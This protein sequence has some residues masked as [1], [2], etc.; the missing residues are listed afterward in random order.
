MKQASTTAVPFMLI[1]SLNKGN[2]MRLKVFANNKGMGLL[3]VMISM[4]ILA[5]GVL[6]LAPMV[7]VSIEG[8]VSSRDRSAVTLL[9]KQKIN[10]YEGNAVLLGN[11][12]CITQSPEYV[13]A[14]NSKYCLMTTVQNIICDSTLPEDIYRIEVTATWVDHQNINQSTS[15]STLILP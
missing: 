7:V 4:I 1:C 12:A 15:F 9:I 10:S 3:E 13:V 14:M 2:N 6:G 8:N 5:I 11:M